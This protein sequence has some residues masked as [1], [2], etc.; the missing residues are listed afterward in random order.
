[1]NVLEIIKSLL[2]LLL[3][4]TLDLVGQTDTTYHYE[5]DGNIEWNDFNGQVIDGLDYK[6]TMFSGVWGRFMRTDSFNVP[7]LTEHYETFFNKLRSWELESNMD[8]IGLVFYQTIY[9]MS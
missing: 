5:G 9:S 2:V 6:G 3:V 8:S 7:I 1:M 4:S